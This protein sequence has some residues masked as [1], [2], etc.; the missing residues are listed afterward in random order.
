MTETLEFA[1]SDPAALGPLRARL[2]SI[3]GLVVRRRA[4]PAARHELG[5]TDILTAL[6][7][8]AALAAAINLLPDF[9]GSRRTGVTVRVK[10]G[11]R[12]IEVRGRDAAEAVRL[13]EKILGD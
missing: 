6:G 13:L 2:L 3:P 9:V 8:G 7:A 1:V 5:A 12:E 10:A 11:D 4:E